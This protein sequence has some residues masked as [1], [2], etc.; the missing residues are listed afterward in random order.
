ILALAADFLRFIG[1]SKG[2]FQRQAPGCEADLLQRP[3]RERGATQNIIDPLLDAGIEIGGRDNL[4]DQAKLIRA[5]PPDAASRYQVA[6]CHLKRYLPNQPKQATCARNQAE[7]GF[8]QSKA[9]LARSD[10]DVAGQG[11]FETST[12]RVTVDSRNDRF[13]QAMSLGQSWPAWPPAAP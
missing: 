1:R 10:D 6:H 5:L 8:R 13:A 12:E 7:L 3:H 11:Q 4:I 2:L 9:R